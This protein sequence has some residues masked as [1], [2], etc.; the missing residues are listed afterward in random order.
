L[1]KAEPLGNFS[2]AMIG[3]EYLRKIP[4]ACSSVQTTNLLPPKMNGHLNFQ[5]STGK[6]RMF[7]K[8]SKKSRDWD[9]QF[10]DGKFKV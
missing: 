10:S 1:D 9:G 2:A 4:L 3:N 8:L 6:V 5:G 7:V